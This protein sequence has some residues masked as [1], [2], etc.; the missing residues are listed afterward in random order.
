MADPAS[1]R[2]LLEPDDAKVTVRIL[3]AANAS[4]GLDNVAVSLLRHCWYVWG[5]SRRLLVCPATC[6]ET[7]NR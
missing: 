6:Q 4:Q 3:Q 2:K 7:D 5:E 1:V